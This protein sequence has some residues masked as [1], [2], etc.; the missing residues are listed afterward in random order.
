MLQILVLKTVIF[1]GKGGGGHANPNEFRC[2]F[3]GLRKKAQHSFPKIGWGGGVR[4]R[5][6]VFR[7]FSEFGRGSLPLAGEITQVKE[8]IPWVR[9][10]SGNVLF[11]LFVLFRFVLWVA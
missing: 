5:L 9:C 1:W 11:H 8:S 3:S 10:A 4:G 7:K 2:K 6:E